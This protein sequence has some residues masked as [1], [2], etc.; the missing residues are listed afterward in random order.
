M[1]P[2]L[3]RRNRRSRRWTQIDSF[4]LCAFAPLRFFGGGRAGIPNSEFF[5]TA[6]ND[7]SRLARFKRIA[8]QLEELIVNLLE[9]RWNNPS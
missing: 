1:P 5:E 3:P 4:L 8:D 6:M 2:T 7:T 9:K